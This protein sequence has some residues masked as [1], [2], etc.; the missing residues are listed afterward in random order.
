MVTKID[1]CQLE[2]DHDRGVIYVH[3]PDGF[4]AIRIC[5]L[6]RPIPEPKFGDMIDITHMHGASWSGADVDRMRKSK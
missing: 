6:P 2:I 1:N 5:S 4:T 3:H